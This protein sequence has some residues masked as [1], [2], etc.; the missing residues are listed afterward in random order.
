MEDWALRRECAKSGVAFVDTTQAAPAIQYVKLLLFD[1]ATT[2][3][4]G[5][6]LSPRCVDEWPDEMHRRGP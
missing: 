5:F 3:K 1:A 4:G 2:G 6:E